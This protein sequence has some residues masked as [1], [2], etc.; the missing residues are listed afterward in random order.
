MNVLFVLFFSFFCFFSEVLLSPSFWWN[1]K[2][3]PFSSFSDKTVYPPYMETLVTSCGVVEDHFPQRIL[4]FHASG[5]VQESN[6][7]GQETQGL[8][9]TCLAG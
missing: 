9:G 1:S 4:S 6:E 8:E 3:H 5:K 7:L 2:G